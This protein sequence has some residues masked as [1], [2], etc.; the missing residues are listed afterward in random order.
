MDT[1]SIAALMEFAILVNEVPRAGWNKKFPRGHKCRSRTVKN[2]ESS[3]AHMYGLAFLAMLVAD[4]FGV[5]RLKLIEMALSHDV[6]EFFSKD[7]V[8]VT[9]DGAFRAKLERAKRKK[10]QKAI[11]IIARKGGRLG[12]RIKRLWEEFEEGKTPEAKLLHQLDKLEM[13]FQA[14]RYSRKR[15]KFNPL[16][17]FNSSRPYI[18]EPKLQSLF[19]DLEKKCRER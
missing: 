3:A 8:T 9:E 2:P 4:A 1:R 18:L 11:I 16:E 17:F 5:D 7:P 14:E 15:Q 13:L 10:E 19:F 6:V 12:R